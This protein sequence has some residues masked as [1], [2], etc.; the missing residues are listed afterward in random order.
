MTGKAL[1]CVFSP[2]TNSKDYSNFRNEVKNVLCLFKLAIQIFHPNLTAESR[3][4]IPF[5]NIPSFEEELTPTL[6]LIH[7]KYLGGH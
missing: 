6:L 3:I 2:L 1:H 4:I 5:S 7:N